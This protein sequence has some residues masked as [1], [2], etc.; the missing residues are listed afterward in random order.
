MGQRMGDAV[1]V[2]PRQ[3]FRQQCCGHG[4]VAEEALLQ[5]ELELLD[6]SQLLSTAITGDLCHVGLI[7]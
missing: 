1:W 7:A 3:G 6:Q 4:R 2:G 5:L